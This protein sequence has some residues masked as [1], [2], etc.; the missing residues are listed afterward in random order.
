MSMRGRRSTS[1]CSELGRW[2]ELADVRGARAE[3]ASGV[4]KAALL[5]AQARA[6]EQAGERAAAAEVVKLAAQHAPDDV[7]GLVDYV[8]VLA[9]EGRGREAAE[10]LAARVDEA[11]DRG[12]PAAQVAALQLRLSVMH[13]DAGEPGKASLVLAELFAV[14][15]RVRAGARAGGGARARCRRRRQRCGCGWRRSMDRTGC[16]R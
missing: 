10:V 7:S 5:R 1:C 13:D 3:L 14:A 6:F 2:R 16:A 11:L 12:A 9:R 8:D 4:E 15:S